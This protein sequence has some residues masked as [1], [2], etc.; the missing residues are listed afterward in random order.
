MQIS[1]S[2]WYFKIYPVGP[3]DKIFLKNVLLTS[4]A[5]AKLLQLCLTLCDPMGCSLPGFSVQGILQVSGRSGGEYQ[6]D[7]RAVV[8]RLRWRVSGR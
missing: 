8:T 3:L 2:H 1:V 7:E 5:A 4:A 6:A